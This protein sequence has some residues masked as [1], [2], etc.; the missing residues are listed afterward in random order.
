M[1]R[2]AI[3]QAI[4]EVVPFSA[5]EIKYDHRVFIDFA[6]AKLVFECIA[7]NSIPLPSKPAFCEPE[8]ARR[9]KVRSYE[10][11][12]HIFHEHYQ[13]PDFESKDPEEHEDSSHPVY[14]GAEYDIIRK[15]ASFEGA[16]MNGA[17]CLAGELILG[18]KEHLGQDEKRYNLSDALF[19]E[20]RLKSLS[21]VDYW[22]DTFDR[23]DVVK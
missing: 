5:N 4:A 15:I 2:T 19:I 22:Q 14:P 7:L 9:L 11:F 23:F 17:A 1:Q 20:L 16:V 12:H 13:F 18:V 6:F 8:Q 3:C 21:F 10:S